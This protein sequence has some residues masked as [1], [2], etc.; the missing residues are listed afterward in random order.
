MRVKYLAV[1]CLQDQAL[2]VALLLITGFV[3]GSLSS[4]AAAEDPSAT[5]KKPAPIP[6]DPDSPTV[7]V[8]VGKTKAIRVRDEG[9]SVAWPEE[10]GNLQDAASNPE[11][12]SVIRMEKLN[13]VAT[14]FVTGKSIGTASLVCTYKTEGQTPTQGVFNCTVHVTQDDDRINK[15]LN[16]YKEQNEEGLTA[17]HYGSGERVVIEGVAKSPAQMSAILAQLPNKHL[18]REHIVVNVKY[19]CQCYC[20]TRGIIGVHTP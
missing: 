3:N 2:L 8:A 10:T 12:L 16:S 18:L 20:C 5:V 4:A 15:I 14:F 17:R 9:F 19:K 11:V 6:E 1:R 13:G 7:F